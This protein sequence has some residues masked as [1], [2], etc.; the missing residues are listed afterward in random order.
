MRAMDPSDDKLGDGVT[1]I[2]EW[3]LWACAN[4]MIRQHGDNA[5]PFAAMRSDA[6]MDEGDAGGA[7]IWR[8]ISTRID[9]L[10][11]APTGTLQ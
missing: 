11:L 4:E 9:Q 3:E 1:T 5:G 7:R 8:L 6:L 10:L 2:T